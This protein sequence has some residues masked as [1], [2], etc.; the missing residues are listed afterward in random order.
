MGMWPVAPG[1]NPGGRGEGWR[2]PSPAEP[3]HAGDG[4]QRPLRSR[5][6]PRLM[7][8]VGLRAA[9]AGW[10]ARVG[11]RQGS[12]TAGGRGMFCHPRGESVVAC[13]SHAPRRAGVACSAGA[14]ARTPWP[15]RA[16]R[17][18]GTPLGGMPCTTGV[19]R[20]LHE[21]WRTA[22]WRRTTAQTAPAAGVARGGG[23]GGSVAGWPW[24]VTVPPAVTGARQ[25]GAPEVA[26]ALPVHAVA[27]GAGRRAAPRTVGG[28]QGRAVGGPPA[29]ADGARSRVAR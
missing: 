20:A 29:S 21:G 8:G 22:S 6:Q 10:Q 12:S 23:P 16:M 15:V 25:H 27:S 26:A 14:Q 28:S 24:R 9:G 5:F 4:C 7:P 1:A 2:C 11:G 3:R 17:L 18:G 13:R 19:W